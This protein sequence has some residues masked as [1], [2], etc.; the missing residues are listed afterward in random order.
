VIGLESSI[1]ILSSAGFH[2]I[3]EHARRLAARLIDRVEALGWRPFRPLSDPSASSHNVSLRHAEHESTMIAARLASEH[4]VT[5]VVEQGDSGSP[6]TCT[7]TM[8]MSIG[9]SRP[10]SMFRS[11]SETT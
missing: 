11:S 4:Q 10:F 8:S 3:D 6:S 1:A 5:A 2:R 9:S 7:T